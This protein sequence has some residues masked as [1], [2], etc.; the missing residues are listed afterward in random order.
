MDF[1]IIYIRYWYWSKEGLCRFYRF[2]DYSLQ[3]YGTLVENCICFLCR[4][5]TQV[6]IEGFSYNLYTILLLIKGRSLSILIISWFVFTELWD[7][8]WKQKHSNFNGTMH[9]VQ[10]LK[11]ALIH[12]HTKPTM[13]IFVKFW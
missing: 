12:F 8:T 13:L 1:H 3:S 7:L 6:G 9:I 5:I 11:F 2:S 10:Y 4:T